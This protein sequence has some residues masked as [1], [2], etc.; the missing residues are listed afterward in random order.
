MPDEIFPFF[1]MGKM[2]SFF[3]EFLSEICLL[4]RRVMNGIKKHNS[5]KTI[6]LWTLLETIITNNFRLDYTNASRKHNYICIMLSLCRRLVISWSCYYYCQLSRKAV[7]PSVSCDFAFHS[8]L[9]F[10]AVCIASW[11]E[12][13][14]TRVDDYDVWKTLKTAALTLYLEGEQNVISFVKQVC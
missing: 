3:F 7:R 13:P 1:T 8:I 4:F 12:R 6:F 5:L 9:T 10:Y 14:Y 2:Y 11:D